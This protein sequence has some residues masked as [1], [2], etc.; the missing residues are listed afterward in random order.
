MA[1]AHLTLVNVS[2]KNILVATDFSSYSNAAFWFAASIAKRYGA[3][4]H[5]AHVI[6]PEG[7]ALGYV[8]GD[9][10][11]YY[12]EAHKSAALE[13]AKLQESSVLFCIKHHE[14]IREGEIVETLNAIAR[15]NDIDLVV[16]GTGGAG[17]ISKLLIGSVAEQTLRRIKVPVLTIGPE[18]GTFEG[19]IPIT[20]SEILYPTDFSPESLAALPYAASLAKA[21]MAQLSLLYVHSHAAVTSFAHAAVLRTEYGRE[22]AKLLPPDVDLWSKPAIR[23][24]FGKPAETILQASLDG[25][26]NLI[27]LG[28]RDEREFADHVPWSVASKVIREAHCPVLTVRGPHH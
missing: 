4:L 9:V 8:G 14:I 19:E 25:R 1:T 2:I 5:T 15:D 7:L 11:R 13:M 3:T 20:L 22:L 6:A 17:G 24:E 21:N 26:A 28:V 27:V 12:R 18:V 10:E 23:V 16:L